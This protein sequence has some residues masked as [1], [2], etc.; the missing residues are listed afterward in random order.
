MTLL[1]GLAIRS[2][3][4]LAVGLLLSACLAKRSAA[5]RHRALA[6]ALLSAALVLPFSLVLPE[7]NVTLPARATVRIPARINDASP[8]VTPARASDALT[9]VA[10]APEPSTRETVSPIVVAWLAGVL[11]AAGTL[12]T[13]LVRVSR[14]A[15]R[16]SRVEDRRWLQILDTVADRYGLTRGIVISQ[17]DAADLLATWGILRPQVLLPDHAHAWTLDRVRVVLCHELAHIRRH[18]WLVQIGAE[19]LRAILW[20]NPLAWMVCTRLRRE[21]EQACDDD[22]LGMDVGGSEYAA[23]LIELVRQCRRPGSTWAS[24]TPMAHPSTLERRIAAMLNPR[25]DRQAPSR[26]AMAALGAVLLLVTLPVAAVRARQAGPAPL[27]GTIYDATGG[28]LPGVKVALV[29]ANEITQVVTSNA[30]GRFEFPPVIPGKYVLAATLVGFRALRH[31]FELRD[32][33]DWDRAVTLQVGD[34]M[35]T[36]M[37][38]E[39]RVAVPQ[40]QVPFRV[41]P[42][43]VRVGGNV[44][45]PRKELDVHPVYP[46]AMREAGL[47][48]VVPIE[49]VIGR[50]GSVAS[51][52]VLSAQVHPDFAISA[53]DAV[54]QWRFTP[55]LLNGVPVDVVMTVSVQFDLEDPPAPLAER[56]AGSGVGGP[57]LDVAN[58]CCPEYIEAMTERIRSNWDEQQGA[59]GQALMKFTVR[60]DGMLTNVEIAKTSGNPR[61]DLES[62]RAVLATRQVP[63]LPDEFRRSDLT[64]HLN[65][66]YKQ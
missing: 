14:V 57:Q 42:Q 18:D 46:A 33:R 55:T 28:V 6:A 26:R 21:S 38:R 16:A 35:E 53:V 27:S 48:G 29:D 20:F 24:A 58:F 52:R 34:V 63:A 54:R 43:A 13:G 23:H 56:A 40:Q 17:T 32:A 51:V 25:L 10:V 47:T 11:V 50:D 62:R 1:L 61:L 7:W 4:I 59:A 5:L 64:V 12:I 30:S 22:V 37:I 41:K 39:S 9:S 49:A 36:I 65:F 45:A 44:R 66:E 15:A 8:S 2:F 31:E 3:V 19:T 60:R